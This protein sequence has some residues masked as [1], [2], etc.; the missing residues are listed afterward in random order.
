MK[1]FQFSIFNF[2]NKKQSGFTIVEVLVTSLIFSIIAITISAIFVQIIN[3]QRRGIS[4]QKIQTN[5]LFVLEMMSRDIR[6]S[7]IA[8]QESPNCSL[9]TITITH[10]SKDVIVYRATNGFIEKSESGGAFVAISGSDVNFSRMN[11]CVTGSGTNDNQTPRVAIITTA[12]NKTGKEILK[13]NFQTT[14]SSRDLF[15]ELQSP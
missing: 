7:K 15:D 5:S 13:I 8:N 11:F 10:P 4:I 2:K 6:V 1:N 12:E 14:V 9:T 3:L